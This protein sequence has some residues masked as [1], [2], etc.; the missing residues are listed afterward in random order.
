MRSVTAKD[1]FA[2]AI[3]SLDAFAKEMAWSIED[4]LENLKYLYSG[5]LK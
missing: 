4:D 5:Y 2:N 3:I 1:A